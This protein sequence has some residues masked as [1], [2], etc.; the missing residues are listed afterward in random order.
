MAALDERGCAIG[1][2]G[3]SKV[4]LVIACQCDARLPSVAQYGMPSGRPSFSYVIRRTIYAP[5]T[6]A[7]W[8]IALDGMTAAEMTSK[9]THQSKVFRHRRNR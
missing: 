1:P 4:F 8:G 6:H 3:S 9:P 2:V 7:F 5:R